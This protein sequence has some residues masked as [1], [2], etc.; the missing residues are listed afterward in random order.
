LRLPAAALR[1]PAAA[2]RLRA[3]DRTG[4]DSTAEARDR[5]EVEHVTGDFDQHE[6]AV[7]IE[8]HVQQR[9]VASRSAEIS[10][11]QLRSTAGRE[12]VNSLLRFHALVEV[13]VAG[14]YD[15]DA[16]AHEQRLQHRAQIFFGTVPSPR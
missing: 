14:E 9:V 13:L 3:R 15:V 7:T 4:V 1:L 12:V 6:M 11:A 16:V 8:S 5:L 2:L 10:A